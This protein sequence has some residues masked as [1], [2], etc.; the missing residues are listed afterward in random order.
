MLQH[1][2]TQNLSQLAFRSGAPESLEVALTD[3][4]LAVEQPYIALL[5][6]ALER[7]PHVIHIHVIYIHLY[8]CLSIY[9]PNVPVN[10][11]P[12]LHA[13]LLLSLL[14]MVVG[15]VLCWGRLLVRELVPSTSFA[16]VSSPAFLFSFGTFEN[17]DPPS[18]LYYGPNTRPKTL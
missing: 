1:P 15:F 5:I 17:Q 3:A 2:G 18:T 7:D 12:C 10:A 16:P 11:I 14:R 4:L 9:T 8:S 6:K 13:A